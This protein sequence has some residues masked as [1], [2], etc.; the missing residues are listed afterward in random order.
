MDTPLLV[1]F[2][3]GVVTCADGAWSWAVPGLCPYVNVA[4]ITP[5]TGTP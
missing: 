2:R 4:Q 5:M 1:D 3:V